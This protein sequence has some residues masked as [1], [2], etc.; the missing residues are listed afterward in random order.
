MGGTSGYPWSIFPGGYE[1]SLRHELFDWL[2]STAIDHDEKA[3]RAF[4]LDELLLS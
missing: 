4:A 1:C 2:I 3:R